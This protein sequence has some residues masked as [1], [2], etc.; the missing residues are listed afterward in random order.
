[1]EAH[2]LAAPFHSSMHSPAKTKMHRKRQ[3]EGRPRESASG[4][5]AESARRELGLPLEKGS[6]KGYNDPAKVYWTY[7]HIDDPFSA[8]GSGFC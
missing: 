1:M 7:G 8:A 6:R 3:G 2:R 4:A 5:S